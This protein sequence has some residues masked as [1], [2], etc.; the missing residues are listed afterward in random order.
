MLIL[1]FVK[2]SVLCTQVF[3]IERWVWYHTP[4]CIKREKCE[5]YQCEFKVSSYKKPD[6]FK[7]RKKN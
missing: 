4:W 2:H 5:V 1:V 3:V 6:H 7:M